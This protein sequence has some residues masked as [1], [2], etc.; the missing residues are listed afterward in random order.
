MYQATNLF[1]YALREP[2]LSLKQQPQMKQTVGA[3]LSECVG[4][5]VLAEQGYVDLT[6]TFTDPD[7]ITNAATSPDADEQAAIS[8]K[9]LDNVPTVRIIVKKALI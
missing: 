8:E 7:A 5:D 6:I 2:G 4:R 3:L 1:F 9:I